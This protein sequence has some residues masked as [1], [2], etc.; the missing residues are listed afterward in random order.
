MGR[1]LN[2]AVM[3]IKLYKLTIEY[4]IFKTKV[5]NIKNRSH[6]NYFCFNLTIVRAF[7]LHVS[8]IHTAGISYNGMSPFVSPQLHVRPPHSG[9]FG[10]SHGEN[11]YATEIGKLYKSGLALLF[12]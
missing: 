8:Y 1:L 11:I 4:I 9:T 5:I 2:T 7:D 12:R 6:P 3:K 10:V